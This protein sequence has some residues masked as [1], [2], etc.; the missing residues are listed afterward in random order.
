MHKLFNT[1]YKDAGL[2]IL[3]IA[4]GCMMLTHGLPKVPMLFHGTVK[5]FPVMG[6]SPTVSL[7]I[8]LFAQVI[9]SILLLFGMATRLALIPL[10]MTMLVAVVIIHHGEP[11][12]KMEPALH[13]LL[14]YIVLFLTGP[15][16]FSVDHLFKKK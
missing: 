1:V 10:L 9:C 8:T 14:V 2:L 7:A 5:F 11:F 15:G 6:M 3:R 4:I 12:A 16:T 13:F